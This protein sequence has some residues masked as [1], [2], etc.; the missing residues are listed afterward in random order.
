MYVYQEFQDQLKRKAD[1]SYETLLLWK[2]GHPPLYNNRN[3]SL[4]GLGNL[5]RK[6]RKQ[7]KRFEEYDQIIQI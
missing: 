4:S 3:G 1:G 2:P 6:L 7:P 5:I